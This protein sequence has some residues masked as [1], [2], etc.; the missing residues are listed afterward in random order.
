MLFDREEIEALIEYHEFERRSD[1]H[2][3]WLAFVGL[4]KEGSD[5]KKKKVECSIP[6]LKFRIEMRE[7]RIKELKKELETY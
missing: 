7:S 1:K 4:T 2:Y 5:D 6:E 3:L